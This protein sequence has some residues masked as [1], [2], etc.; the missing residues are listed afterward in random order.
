[1]PP[2]FNLEGPSFHNLGNHQASPAWQLGTRGYYF[3]KPRI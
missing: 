1:M 2:Q 3:I